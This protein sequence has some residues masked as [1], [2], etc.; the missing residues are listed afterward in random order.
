MR[1][2]KGRRTGTEELEF[3]TETKSL[4]EELKALA[5]ATK[6]IIEATSLAQPSFLQIST[7]S[8]LVAFN[9]FSTKMRRVPGDHLRYPDEISQERLNM[10]AK[11]IAE[12]KDNYKRSMSRS[13]SASEF[14]NVSC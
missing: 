14:A 1:T 13:A 12:K 5:T 7:M 10:F 2:I 11:V 8:D 9:P 6:I 4:D 3:K